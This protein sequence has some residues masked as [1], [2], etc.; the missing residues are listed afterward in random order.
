MVSHIDSTPAPKAGGPLIATLSFSALLLRNNDLAE[1]VA[2][3][4]LCAT[5]PICLMGGHKSWHIRGQT[6]D[7]EARDLAETNSL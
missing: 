6:L 1:V 3:G 7:L 5:V 4:W 2:C